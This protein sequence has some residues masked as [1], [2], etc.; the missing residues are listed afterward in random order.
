MVNDVILQSG[1]NHDVKRLESDRDLKAAVSSIVDEF[2]RLLRSLFLV[3][4]ERRMGTHCKK[5]KE[6]IQT[7]SLHHVLGGHRWL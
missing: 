7:S 6:A 1:K 2:L 4:K 3:M 5:V